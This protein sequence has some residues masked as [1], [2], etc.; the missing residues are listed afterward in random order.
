MALTQISTDG[1]KNDAISAGKIP[2]N[3][4]GSSEI[5]DDAVGASQIADDG[6]AQAAVADE[7][8]DE[9][10]LQISNAGS[11][12]QFLQKQSG[13]TGGLTWATAITDTSDKA[14]IN[15][16]T[17]TGT[18]TA[19]T[20]TVDNGTSSKVSINSSTH[21]ASVANEAKLELGFAH[22]GNPDAI[23]YVKLN[24]SGNNAFDGKLTVGVPYNGGSGG[25]ATR[26]VL[27]IKWNGAIGVT[28]E[29][30]GSSGQVL[31][32]GGGSAAPSWAAIPPAGNTVD[33]V[34]DG[35]IA[36]GKPVIVTT[37]GKVKQVQAETAA[38]QPSLVQEAVLASGNAGDPGV[39]IYDPDADKLVH[40]FPLPY[41]ADNNRYSVMSL[42]ANGDGDSLLN[43]NQSIDSAIRSYTGGFEWGHVCYDT[44][45]NRY[46]WGCRDSYTDDLIIKTGAYNTS[47]NIIDWD[48]A[49]TN[50]IGSGGNGRAVRLY[51]DE[52]TNRI[53]CLYRNSDQSNYPYIS[54]GTYNTSTNTID[55]GTGQQLGTVGLSDQD[56]IL[57]KAGASTGQVFAGY[58][59]G[60]DFK[61][62]LITVSNSSNTCTIQTA[63][64]IQTNAAA[65][66][67][68]YNEEAQ[69]IIFAYK[70]SAS[71]YNGRIRMLVINSGS[72][73]FDKS[74][75]NTF[76]INNNDSGHDLVYSYAAKQV[77]CVYRVSAS[78]TTTRMFRITSAAL[79]GITKGSDVSVGNNWGG[80]IGDSP[81][82]M[83]S[84]GRKTAATTSRIFF[85][86]Q[87]SNDKPRMG[88]VKTST[89]SSNATNSNVIGFAENAI[90][91]TATGTI[92]LTGNIVGNQSSLTPG[93][94]YY[95]QGDGTLGTSQ[96]NTIGASSGRSK[97]GV[98]V[99][100][101][102]L[103]ISDYA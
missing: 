50:P 96:D 22:S 67:A 10:R 12:G 83:G 14:P 23:G 63:A 4:V 101:T 25:S 53:V 91:D 16:P 59:S 74:V 28:G 8:I 71:S 94:A 35:A 73:G 39:I 49:E 27:F 70:D 9:A 46:I 93:T 62:N 18:V 37:A 24:E 100:A 41:A 54:I 40:F 44:N 38:A 31:T 60:S 102:T 1:V 7:A 65:I 86:Q 57:I 47:S 90:N 89:A 72:T 97:A 78:D 42:T 69:H 43:S 20:I 2:A 55:W 103:K 82:S 66:R 81:Y 95:V 87:D 79:D 32:S 98:A 5:A 58:R 85:G 52:T 3:A 21:N 11:N 29:S 64:T 34:A 84:S 26:D 17:F 45:N 75:S 77:F 68:V 15:N 36:A 80:A 56:T 76:C 88:S 33:L 13:N 19:P 99:S 51:F 92:K 30:Y 6:V 48:T 61:G